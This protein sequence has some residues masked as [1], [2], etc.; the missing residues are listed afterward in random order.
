M[1]SKQPWKK[2]DC[3]ICRSIGIEVAIFEA[4]TETEGAVFII[5]TFMEKG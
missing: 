3:K 2:C 4:T 1:L 5:F